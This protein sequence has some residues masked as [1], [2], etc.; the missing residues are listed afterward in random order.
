MTSETIKTAVE[1]LEKGGLIIF[2]TETCYGLGAD[3][4]NSVAVRKV[5]LTKNRPLDMPLSVIV[6]SIEMIKEYA[7]ISRETERLVAE[8]MPGPLT[9]IVKNKSLPPLLCGGGNKIGFRI[10]DNVIALELTKQ[11]GKPI[12]ATSANLHGES[13]PYLVPELKG[14]DFTINYGELPHNKPSTVYDTI[15]KRTLRQGDIKL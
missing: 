2:P 11:L 12:T 4:T 6:P 13:D 5:F 9:L 7:V 10:P 1:I 14:I 3:A 15:L 8:H